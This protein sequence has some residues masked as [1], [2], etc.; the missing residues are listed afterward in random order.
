[1]PAS[2]NS[3][4]D[5]P[6][7]ELPDR[8][9][10]WV[11]KPDSAEEGLGKLAILTP[12]TVLRAATSEIRTGRRV[13]LGWDLTKLEVAGFDRQPCEHKIVPLLNGFA[14]DDIYTFNPRE[15]FATPP[16]QEFPSPFESCL[17]GE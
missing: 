2:S 15:L 10:V 11:G 12:E 8:K 9:R 7:D 13:T 5:V 16:F 1:M 3:P 17:A 6:F 4:F 14:F